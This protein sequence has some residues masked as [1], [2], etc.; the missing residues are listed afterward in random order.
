MNASVAPGMVMLDIVGKQLTTDDRRRLG[1]PLTGGVIL[2]SRNYDSPEQLEELTGEIHALRTP[3][4]LIAVDHEG[5]RV[6]RFREGFTRLPPMRALGSLWDGQPQQACLLAADVGYVL[7]A[8]LRAHGVDLSF[9]PVLDLDFG[10]SAVIGNRA[11][12]SQPEAVIALAG[13]LMRGLQRAGMAA[14]GKHFP[15]HGF[16]AADSHTD[17]P[18]D[19]RSLEQIEVADLIPFRALINQGLSAVMPAHVIYPAVDDRPAGFSRIW[20]TEILRTRMNFQGVIFSDDLSMEGARVAGDVV[21]RAEAALDAGCDM[22]LVCNRPDA[23]DELLA[24]LNRENSHV[25]LARLA[26][27]YSPAPSPSLTSIR[28]T[29]AYGIAVQGIESLARTSTTTMMANA[30]SVGESG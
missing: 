11:F 26:S 10:N 16:I 14:C 17:V 29:E 15:G 22:V 21:A 7:A 18:V 4:L 6:Q 30:P 28:R 20:L 5:G 1:H 25:S 2:F 12:H 13:A 24:R 19:H 9:T 8:E 3:P 27:L 23:A